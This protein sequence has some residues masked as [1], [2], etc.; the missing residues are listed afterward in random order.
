MTQTFHNSYRLISSRQRRT[1]PGFRWDRLAAPT[2]SA[3]VEH[4]EHRQL[5]SGALSVV[6]AFTGTNGIGPT[7][8]VQDASGNLFGVTNDSLIGSATPGPG[9]VFEIAAGSNAITVLAPFNNAEYAGESLIIDANG[10]L[11]GTESASNHANLPGLVFE[12]AKGTNTITTLAT[13]PGFQGTLGALPGHGSV[14]AVDSSG[15]LFGTDGFGNPFE[16]VH[17]SGTVTH[18]TQVASDG[19]GPVDASDLILAPNGSLF[20]TTFS[21][22]INSAGSIFEIPAGTSNV[23]TLASFAAATTGSKPLG[24][25]LDS[26]GDLFGFCENGGANGLGTVFELPN[27][28]NTISLFAT[29]TAATGDTPISKPVLGASGNLY[30]F[31]E[32]DG[33]NGFGSFFDVS[34]GVTPA[35]RPALESSSLHGSGQSASA[36]QSISPFSVVGGTPVSDVVDLNSSQLV[37]QGSAGIVANN[38][39]AAPNDI[40]KGVEVFGTEFGEINP[41]SPGGFGA[42]DDYNPQSSPPASPSTMRLKQGLAELKALRDALKEKLRGDEAQEKA[43]KAVMK[44]LD[45]DLDRVNKGIKSEDNSIKM[46]DNEVNMFNKLENQ[47]HAVQSEAVPRAATDKLKTAGAAPRFRGSAANGNAGKIAQLEKK[48][49]AVEAVEAKL[50]AKINSDTSTITGE[51]AAASALEAQIEASLPPAPA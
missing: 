19:L 2:K 6:A 29:F 40:Q 22:G 17:G 1:S 35:A 23:Q 4:L 38:S 8:V 31:T 10:N 25:A 24:V 11:F 15:D 46:Y 27:G 51:E 50:L 32:N 20:G 16:V 33:A 18:L 12:V 41:D 47:L 39:G 37:G 44:E 9:E 13:I 3:T 48:I 36:A 26:S 42:V 45:S 34:T 7:A 5:L 30:G 21:G 28:S 49:A 43:D 14:T